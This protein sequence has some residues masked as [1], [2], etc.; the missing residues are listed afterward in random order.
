M[1]LRARYLKTKQEARIVLETRDDCI[2]LV[3]DLVQKM[4]DSR[5]GRVTL[6][7]KLED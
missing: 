5:D 1:G 6:R 7:I 3:N 2:F 4:N